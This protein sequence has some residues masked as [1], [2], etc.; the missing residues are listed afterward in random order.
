MTFDKKNIYN[1]LK[2]IYYTFKVKKMWTVFK[3]EEVAI[4]VFSEKVV[5]L[6][7]EEEML[8]VPLTYDFQSLEDHCGISSIKPSG[9]LTP[10]CIFK[11]VLGE[12]KVF[13][14]F[15]Q[16]LCW[17]QKYGLLQQQKNYVIA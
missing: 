14:Y 16:N 7:K 10:E 1:F 6:E 3:T 4:G 15:T 13:P 12:Q 8:V 11:C 17:V 9:H 5:L 2:D